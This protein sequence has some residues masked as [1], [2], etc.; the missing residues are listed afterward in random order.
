MTKKNQESARLEQIIRQIS[1]NVKED[2]LPVPEVA[3][4]GRGYIWCYYPSK[5][6]F[7]RIHRGIKAYIIDNKINKSGR[8]L[9]Y[10]LNGRVIEIEPNELINTGFD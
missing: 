1:G 9:I 3:I 10:T 5:H 6:E 2:D 7:I 4:K 8:I